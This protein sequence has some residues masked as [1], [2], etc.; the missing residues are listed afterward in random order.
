M[1]GT[2]FVHLR[3]FTEDRYG[4][5]AWR[6]VL[7]AAGLGPRVYLPI[8]SY[9]DGELT[10]IVVAAARATN[11]AIPALLE[12]FG[13]Y[14]APHLLAM[15]RHLLKPNWRTLDILQHAEATAHR[16]VRVEQPGASP[17]YLET[18]RKS[19]REVTVTYTS[20]RRL[21]HVA[22]GIIR[23]LS[24]HLDEPVLIDEPQCM[25]RG[26]ERCLIRVRLQTAA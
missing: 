9:P 15:Y 20:A 23:G 2:M 7:V 13:E 5:D 6:D 19:E 12:A 25:H 14:V 24:R 26:A 17:P 3:K 4:V 1:H 22:K 8:T 10:A 11:Q 21:C 16:A 18:E